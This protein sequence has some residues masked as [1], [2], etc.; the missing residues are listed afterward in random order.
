MRRQSPA[1][2]SQRPSGEKLAEGKTTAD[3]AQE[4][5]QLAKKH[6]YLDGHIKIVTGREDHP[7]PNVPVLDTAYAKDATEVAER[8][9]ALGG[10]RLADELKTTFR[11]P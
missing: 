7:P 6:A 11:A 5:F 10:Y 8:R 4:S 3:W 1:A 9:M 2:A